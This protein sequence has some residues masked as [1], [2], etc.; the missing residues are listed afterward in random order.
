MVTDQDSPPSPTVSALELVINLI[1]NPNN[2]PIVEYTHFATRLVEAVAS[3]MESL[4]DAGRAESNAADANFFYPDY[5]HDDR[6]SKALR[7]ISA[8]LHYATTD[9][10]HYMPPRFAA[11]QGVS[12]SAWAP[13]GDHELE[14]RELQEKINKERMVSPAD[15][16]NLKTSILSSVQ[17]MLRDTRPPPSHPPAPPR[18]N[19][20]PISP[21]V[22]FASTAVSQPLSQPPSVPIQPAKPAAPKPAVKKPVEFVVRFTSGKLPREKRTEPQLIVPRINKAFEAVPSAS[23]RFKAIGAIWTPAGNL[24]VSFLPNTNIRD[25]SKEGHRKIIADAVVGQ[26]DIIAEVGINCRWSKLVVGNVVTRA[27]MEEAVFT[28]HEL[29]N[30]LRSCNPDLF[31][32]L[33]FTQQPRWV[34]PDD[35]IVK[36]RSSFSFAFADEDGTIARKLKSTPLWMFANK[37]TLREWRDKPRLR[38]CERCWR[39]THATAGCREVKP[40]CVEC[41]DKHQ[42][43]D[44]RARCTQCTGT[45]A[46]QACSHQ[47]CLNCKGPHRA[48]DASCPERAKFRAPVA[49]RVNTQQNTTGMDQ[50]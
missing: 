12:A 4:Y 50:S 46:E 35:K 43:S 27:L 42:T 14:Y 37:V 19:P 1:R 9:Q 29:A 38:Q 33:V 26:E 17:S 6:F 48:D 20:T 3:G 36:P 22:T 31:E 18:S 45:P 7:E 2:V 25:L 24:K 40:N 21:P 49:E 11:P 41:G 15:L 16:E 34:V 28:E 39:F 8:S 10:S 44:H 13:G 32:K 47:K 30:E 5:D 23:G